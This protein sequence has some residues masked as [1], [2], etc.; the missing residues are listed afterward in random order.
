MSL[1]L[2]EYC[3]LGWWVQVNLVWATSFHQLIANCCPLSLGPGG[4]ES[5]DTEA[6]DLS[7][8]GKKSSQL[9]YGL[10]SS[11]RTYGRSEAGFLQEVT[12]RVRGGFLWKGSGGDTFGSNYT[13]PSKFPGHLVCIF[14]PF[15]RLHFSM[16]PML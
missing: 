11:L 12:G 13:E 15:L 9:L 7:L 14:L 5:W 16:I 2:Q 1:P 3:Q 10:F 8:Q 4:L 6:P